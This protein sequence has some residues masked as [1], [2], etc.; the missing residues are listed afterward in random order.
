MLVDILLIV[1]VASATV[2]INRSV[3]RRR[4]RRTPIIKVISRDLRRDRRTPI[5]KVISRDLRR[6]RDRAEPITILNSCND[7]DTLDAA[8]ID[9]LFKYNINIDRYGE[10]IEL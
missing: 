9:F 2:F 4:D 6:V 1:L 7:L 5:I 3:A 8:I 10:T